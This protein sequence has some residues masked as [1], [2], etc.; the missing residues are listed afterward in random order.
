[1]VQIF[2]KNKATSTWNDFI[3][4]LQLGLKRTSS[5]YAKL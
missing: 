4:I 3:Q 2:K 1:M 5:K